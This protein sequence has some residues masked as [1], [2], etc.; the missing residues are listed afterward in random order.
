MKRLIC[1][2]CGQY[3]DFP[4]SDLKPKECQF[5]F[6]E[7][8]ENA[9]LIDMPDS[10]ILI[11]VIIKL[12]YQKTG[13]I[14]ELKGSMPYILGREHAGKEIFSK[15]K[16]DKKAVISRKHASIICKGGIYF[17]KDENS[18]NGTFV[19]IERVR[20][21][22]TPLEIENN[23]IVYFGREAFLVSFEYIAS[24][25]QEIVKQNIEDVENKKAEEHN[26]FCRNCGFHTDAIPHNKICPQCNSF[27]SF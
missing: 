12:I 25:K 21:K 11:P 6:S 10:N 24:D 14:I 1:K 17:I 9:E 3:T 22:D 19:G 26:Y 15:I 18:L 20:C 5:C 23:C 2:N 7:F 27:N 16:S 4:F 13:Q 8:D